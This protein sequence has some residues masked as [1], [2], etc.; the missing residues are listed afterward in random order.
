MRLSC[1]VDAAVGD[2]GRLEFVGAAQLISAVCRLSAV[3]EHGCDVGR[4]IRVE[5]RRGIAGLL[6][7]RIFAFDCPHDAV[8]S[9]VR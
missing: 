6:I 4:V 9:A 3:V 1:H 8:R 2:G 5:D 7:E